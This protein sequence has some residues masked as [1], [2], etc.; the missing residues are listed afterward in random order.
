MTPDV[1]SANRHI[2]RGRVVT[3]IGL[4]G[5]AALYV[6]ALEFTPPE[7]FQ[8][9]VQKLFY[10]HPPAAYA[11]QMAFIFTGV[12]SLL[13]LLLRDARFDHF[14]EASA[15]VGMVMGLI[16]VITGPIWGRPAWGT[17][18]EWEPRLTFT[19]MELVVF[20]SYF[21][22]R[23]AMREPEE[24]AKFSAVLGLMALVLVPFNHL[25][26][27]YFASQHP[28]PVVG[29]P[30]KPDLPFVMLRTFLTGFGVFTLLY[31]GM[32]M[33]RYGIGA[34][35]AHLEALDA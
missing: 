15:E 13:Y 30:D 9:L 21:A 24:R 29:K 10:L 23:G 17:W 28:L 11:M 8:G 5:L 14:A 19:V 16:V 31:V 27:Y 4:L 26:V 6:L 22:L 1:A 3:L 18:W 33:Q 25:T 20:A 35:R 2:Q 7:R 32:V 34:R 12:S